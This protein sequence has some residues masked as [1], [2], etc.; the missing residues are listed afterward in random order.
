[1]PD[2]LY[3]ARLVEAFHLAFLR[4]L[5]ARLDRSCYVVKGG[6]NLRA[7]FGSPRYSED[8]DLVVAR[9]GPARLAERVDRLLAGTTLG[10]LLR[11]Q[12]LEIGRASKP[13]QTETVQRWKLE[14]RTSGS[15]LPAHTKIEF[16]RRGLAEGHVLEPVLAEVVRP[17][18]LPAPTAQHYTAAAAVRQKIRALAGRAQTQARD[19]WDLDHLFRNTRVDA[20]PL[21]PDVR[22]ALAIAVERV[23]DLPFAHFKAQIVPYLAESVQPLYDSPDSWDRMRELVVDEL[24]RLGR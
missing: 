22:R 11:S 14:L 8:L 20:R 18:G 10:L 21:T 4:A 2:P 24:M 5:E 13:K 12:G 23:R 15:A 3:P 16:S 7:W 17:Y 6:V 9:V 19:I 1:M